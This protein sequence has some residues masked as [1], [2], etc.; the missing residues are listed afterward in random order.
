MPVAHR[1]GRDGHPGV[2][3]DGHDLSPLPARRD[4]DDHERVGLVRD[5]AGRVEAGLALPPVG[6]DDRDVL[7]LRVQVRRLAAEQGPDVGLPDGAVEVADQRVPRHPSR[8]EQAPDA[9]RDPHEDLSVLLEQP[10]H[11]SSHRSIL[12][13]VPGP[14]TSSNRDQK[15]GNSRLSTLRESLRY[16]QAMTAIDIRRV[17]SD[18]KV[19]V[20]CGATPTTGW[21]NFDNSISIRM[22]QYPGISSLL[23]R[24]LLID[25]Q[26]PTQARVSRQK[27]IR[28]T[29]QA[30][31][32]PCAH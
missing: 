24:L 3:R 23:A 21:A 8:D 2:A 6:T 5:E 1:A 11:T 32:I 16:A 12:S 30:A 14:G 4:V 22:A 28:F 13:M 20:G 9:G 31:R 19:N 18:I 7:R 26:S 27:G 17:H 25:R 29:N 10:S 15:I